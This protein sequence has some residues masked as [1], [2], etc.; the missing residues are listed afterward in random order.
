MLVSI[1][2]LH[3]VVEILLLDIWF[4]REALETAV[5][6]DRRAGYQGPVTLRRAKFFTGP[7]G[8]V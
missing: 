1:E 6:P 7:A 2:V 8:K 3:V 5:G 4:L